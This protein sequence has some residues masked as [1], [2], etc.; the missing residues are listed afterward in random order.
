M[1]RKIKY[2]LTIAISIGILNVFSNL[3]VYAADNIKSINNNRLG[4][5]DRYETAAFVSSYGWKNNS[6]NAILVT[7]NDFPDALCSVPLAEKLRAPILLTLKDSLE[8]STL[9]ELKRLQVKQVYIIGGLGVI[10]EGVEKQLKGLG[11][12]FER[13]GGLD[14]YETS[15][16]IAEKIGSVDSVYVVT[17]E[18]FPDALSVAPIAAKKNAPIL[19][20]NHRTWPS[21]IKSYLDKKSISK[22]FIIGGQT[23]IG[24][25]AVD[26]F[27]DS[28]RIYG[29]DRYETNMKIINKFYGDLNFSTIYIATGQDFPDALAGAALAQTTSSPIV[30][31]SLY[32]DENAKNLLYS[33]IPVIKDINLLGGEAVVP[34]SIAYFSEN[35]G[36]A[37][38]KTYLNIP[39]YDGSN[40]SVHPKVLYFPEKFSGWNYWMCY[41]PY[42]R[43]NDLFENPSIVCSNDGINWVVPKGLKNPLV[44]PPV[45]KGEYFSDPHLVYNSDNK[46]LELWYRFTFHNIQDKIFRIF[47]NNGIEWSDP[48]LV[49]TFDGDKR[50]Y[51]PTIIYDNKRYKM[52]YVNEKYELLY[53]ESENTVNWSPDL[54]VNLN[55]NEPYLP[56]HLD[57]IHTEKGYEMLLTTFKRGEREFNNM[58]LEYGVSGDGL[59]YNNITTVLKPTVGT[60]NWDNKQIYRSSF[61]NVNGIYKLYYSA[62]N[63]NT[64]WR[65]GLT[66]GKNLDELYGYSIADN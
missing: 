43:G 61:V 60:N 38:A 53:R 11:I 23:L 52:W 50:G 65:I 44:V 6:N 51:S 32:N 57:M 13:I 49:T 41:T 34:S 36:Q 46:Q 47:L 24:D 21:S 3:D 40:Q 19:L 63:N 28:T 25:Y 4:G 37:N 5:K 27:K 58:V 64:Y 33:H 8:N 31:T 16:K 26:S 62:M 48:Q 15:A 66:Q 17:G 29:K 59:N 1:N 42:P 14:R 39:T 2:I 45:V 7:G 56:W 9:K 35:E 22:A 30:L 12:S 55:L 20:T 18:N 10:S 54:K